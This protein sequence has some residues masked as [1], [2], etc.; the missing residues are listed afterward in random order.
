MEELNTVMRKMKRGKAPGPD[1]L[2]AE[3]FK[4]LD[5]TNRES[6]LHI[7]NHWWAHP[8]AIDDELWQA[9]QFLY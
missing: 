9:D 3:F 8:E 1:Q 2:A 7:L 5:T 4:E 6:L